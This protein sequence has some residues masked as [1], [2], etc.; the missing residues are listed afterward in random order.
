MER[1]NR[2]PWCSLGELKS[3]PLDQNREEE[4]EASSDDPSDDPSTDLSQRDLA[5]RQAV[6]ADNSGGASSSGA[7]Q[8]AAPRQEDYPTTGPNQRYLVNYRRV[9]LQALQ[10]DQIRWEMENLQTW[11]ARMRRIDLIGLGSRE[12]PRDP[13]VDH[14]TAP[15]YPIRR[16]ACEHLL[17]DGNSALSPRT[18]LSEPVYVWVC[19]LCGATWRRVPAGSGPVL[20]MA[21]V[22]WSLKAI[23]QSYWSESLPYWLQT[24]LQNLLS[25]VVVQTVGQRP[26]TPLK[27][28]KLPPKPPPSAWREWKEQQQRQEQAAPNPQK[29]SQFDELD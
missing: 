2:T 20:P 21:S 13:R 14:P 6:E 8:P 1:T 16:A 27:E 5:S 9:V 25:A 7:P 3:P 4:A 28:P 18:N 12:E 29:D 26:Q 22:Q 17:G 11:F 10:M 23:G 24:S 15:P 19:Q